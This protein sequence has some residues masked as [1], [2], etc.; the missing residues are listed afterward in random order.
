VNS[1][2]WGVVEATYAGLG[3]L[4]RCWLRRLVP[5]G[6]RGKVFLDA[7]KL[8]RQR[9][10]ALIR[11]SSAFS[12]QANAPFFSSLAAFFCASPFI[13]TTGRAAVAGSSFI[14]FKSSSPLTFGGSKIERNQI[15]QLFARQAQAF[16]AGQLR[17]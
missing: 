10:G 5:P 9:F 17:S 7:L 14:A 3:F 4:G 8:Q 2:T 16:F 13:T 12:R 11:A 1:N 6:G 15:R